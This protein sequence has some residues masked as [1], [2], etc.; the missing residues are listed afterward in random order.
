MESFPFWCLFFY[1]FRTQDKKGCAWLNPWTSIAVFVT[2]NSVMRRCGGEREKGFLPILFAQVPGAC[3]SVNRLFTPKQ[4]R[5]MKYPENRVVGVDLCIEVISFAFRL[6]VYQKKHLFF[7]INV[8]FMGGYKCMQ[9]HKARVPFVWDVE[10][11][12]IVIY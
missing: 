1:S 4:S 12:W 2:N 7:C 8:T 6:L 10:L 3:S 5:T 11:T 9:H